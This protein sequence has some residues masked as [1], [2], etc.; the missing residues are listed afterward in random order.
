MIT[1]YTNMDRIT[2]L[3]RKEK[4]NNS[5]YYTDLNKSYSLDISKIKKTRKILQFN[6]FFL[7]NALEINVLFVFVFIKSI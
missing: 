6:F 1:K 7:K 2:L 3:L 5:L 4:K